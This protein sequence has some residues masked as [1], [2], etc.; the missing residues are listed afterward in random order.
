MFKILDP[1]Y[2]LSVQRS[3]AFKFTKD[4]LEEARANEGHVGVR[5]SGRYYH[6]RIPIVSLRDLT[7]S[8]YEIEDEVQA[9]W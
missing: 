3:Y 4:Q 5:I 6:F 9:P 2:I 8:Y 7:P 1:L